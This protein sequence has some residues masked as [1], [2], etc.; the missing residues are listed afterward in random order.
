MKFPV[1]FRVFAALNITGFIILLI[2]TV[3]LIKFPGLGLPLI[4]VSAF[5][6]VW[7]LVNSFFWFFGSRKSYPF[8]YYTPL[9]YWTLAALVLYAGS[10]HLSE[11]EFNDVFFLFVLYSTLCVVYS[12]F[13][14]LSM[15]FKPVKNWIAE[16]GIKKF[17]VVP[18][19]LFLGLALGVTSV[20]IAINALDKKLIVMQTASISQALTNNMVIVDLDQR[21]EF[22]ALILTKNDD[23]SGIKALVYFADNYEATEPGD[24]FQ[25]DTI[26]FRPLPNTAL[27]SGEYIPSADKIPLYAKFPNVKAKRLMIVDLTNAGIANNGYAFSPANAIDRFDMAIDRSKYLFPDNTTKPTTHAGYDYETASYD[28]EADY[29]EEEYY[30]DLDEAKSISADMR[31]QLIEDFFNILFAEYDNAQYHFQY[32]KPTITLNGKQFGKYIN[33]HSM[34]EEYGARALQ[35]VASQ[36]SG[37][38]TE[39]SLTHAMWTISGLNIYQPQTEE[40]ELPFSGLNP[41]FVFWAGENLLPE[42]DQQFFDKTSQEIYD[43]MFRRTIWMLLASYE[44]LEANPNYQAEIDAYYQA[45][46][47]PEFYGPGYLY[48]RYGEVD[49]STTF[50]NKV[51]NEF[52]LGEYEYFYFTEPV[53]IGFW[54]RRHLDGSDKA[55]LKLLE[56]ILEKY[57]SYAFG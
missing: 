25:V 10:T 49:Y 57:D 35:N 46:S 55:V 2:Q 23:R 8:L 27:K 54:M 12:V 37:E 3:F 14:L 13:I 31:Y 5:A 22:S 9:V 16:N 24:F 33:F 7:L 40:S 21:T 4:I 29:Y 39:F 45:M 11:R 28:E 20:F 6:T 53:A 1:V 51:Y 50:F 15:F 32:D 18:T 52:P 42:P 44:H 36:V 19:V 38:D 17:E 43:K 26:E 41:A 34:F 47:D 56:Q 30:D 48:E